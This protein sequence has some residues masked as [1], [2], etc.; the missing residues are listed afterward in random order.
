MLH[1][2]VDLDWLAL[3][4]GEDS[5]IN[6]RAGPYRPRGDAGGPAL[7]RPAAEG[8][9]YIPPRLPGPARVSVHSA[10][11]CCTATALAAL[12]ALAVLC[13]AVDASVILTDRRESPASSR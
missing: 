13:A 6:P 9:G 5:V 3:R 4:R 11:R 12:G 7:P 8:G 2:L 1:A 10:M